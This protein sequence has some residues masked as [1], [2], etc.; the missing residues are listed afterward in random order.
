M[1]PVEQD[2]TLGLVLQQLQAPGPARCRKAPPDGRFIDLPSDAAPRRI[3][4]QGIQQ[5]QRNGGVGSLVPA[6]QADPKIGEAALRGDDVDDQAVPT[7][8]EQCGAVG[9]PRP[10]SAQRNLQRRASIPDRDNA[11]PGGAGHRQVAGLDDSSLFGPDQ[12]QGWAQVALMVVLDVG[13]R[14]HAGIQGIG[15]IQAS[16]EAHLDQHQVEMLSR[17]FRKGGSRQHLELGG[18]AERCRDVV[19]DRQHAADG[20]GES[21]P[22]QQLTVDRDSFAIADQVGLGHGSHPQAGLTKR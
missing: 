2:P 8:V 9:L 13:D 10:R 16:A 5:G 17:Q 1:R 18:R 19:R 21:L 6:E 11:A 7:R 12:G 14:R 4:A 22:R 15:R 3:L 20:C